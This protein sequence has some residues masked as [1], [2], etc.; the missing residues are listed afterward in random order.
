MPGLQR[1]EWNGVMREL[2]EAWRLKK[3][4]KGYVRCLIVS[5]P[6]GWELRL[7]HGD[8]LLRSHAFR[9][10]DPLLDAASEWKDKMLAAGWQQPRP[11]EVVTGICYCVE[12]WICEQ[13]PDRGWPHEDCAGPGMPCEDPA[14]AIGMQLRHKLAARRLVE[15]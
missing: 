13:H 8:D 1:I 5:H 11:I 12:G 9:E 6:I 15:T 10:P 2:A 3:P 4:G 7:L 14:C